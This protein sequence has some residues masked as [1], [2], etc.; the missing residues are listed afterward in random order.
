MRGMMLVSVARASKVHIVARADK[1]IL[2][3]CVE[4]L[5]KR[6]GWT[7]S[8]QPD[9]NVDVNYFMPYLLYRRCKGKTAAWF[10]HRE[11]KEH[12]GQNS[13]VARWHRA[14][15][16]V[17]LRITMA[18]KY[19][20]ELEVH[21]PTVNITLPV[22]ARKFK[23]RKLRVGVAGKVYK[24]SRKGERLVQRLVSS[25]TYEVVGAG[26]GWPCPT[27][28]YPWARMQEFYQGLDAFLVTSEVE[29]G[30]VTIMEALACGIPVVAPQGVGF[31][32]EFDILTYPCGDY[33]KMVECLSRLGLGR[34]MRRKQVLARTEDA[35]A[36]AHAK[37]FL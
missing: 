36:R 34:E 28:F 27:K 35:Y 10:T 13:K 1:W 8:P 18:E 26:E 19:A 15:K 11:E 33:S 20:R 4:I 16:N 30:P 29:G 23:P 37:A 6:L 2:G 21:G 22:N 17:D 5:H 25:G 14:A 24:L 3:R 32:D 9:V 31:V 12:G 7:V